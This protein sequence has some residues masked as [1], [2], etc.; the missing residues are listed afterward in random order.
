MPPLALRSLRLLPFVGPSG[1]R[2]GVEQW[3]ATAQ[4][5]RGSGGA[6]HLAT[7]LTATG[8][9]PDPVKLSK[10]SQHGPVRLHQ[11]WQPLMIAAVRDFVA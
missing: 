8:I 11:R 2:F 5:G 3:L 4:Q 1:G 9:P 10:A 7:P 6:D